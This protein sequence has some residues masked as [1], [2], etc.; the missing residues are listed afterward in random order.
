MAVTRGMIIRDNFSSG[1][2]Q[3]R[4]AASSQSFVLNSMTRDE[5]YHANERFEVIIY[6]RVPLIDRSNHLL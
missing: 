4:N 5:K 6:H 3:I 2:T 1:N